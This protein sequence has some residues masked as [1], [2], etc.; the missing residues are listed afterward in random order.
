[1]STPFALLLYASLAVGAAPSTYQPTPE[2]LQKIQDKTAELGAVL[3]KIRARRVDEGLLADVEVFH[4][5]AVW[6]ARYPR[7]EFHSQK[8]VADTLLVLDRGLAR[9]KELASGRPAWPKQKG[10]LVRA[11]R[12]RVDGSVQPYGLFIPPNYDGRKPVRLDVVL[13]G[14]G[15]TLNEVSFIAARSGDVA[16]TGQT[17]SDYIRLDIYGRGNNAYRW[18]GETD[19]FE[20]LASVEKRYKIDPKR[21]V[22]RGFSMGGAGTWHLGLQYPDRW[23]AMEPGAGFTDS[24]RYMKRDDFPPHQEAMLHIYDAVDYALNAFNLPLVAYAGEEDGAAAQTANVRAQLEKEGFHFTAD[25]LDWKTKDINAIF[26]VGPKTGHKF[27]PDSKQQ[28]EAFIK[29]ALVKGR[30]PPEHIRFVTYTV[31]YNRCF[32]VQVALLEQEYQRAEVDAQRNSDGSLQITTKNVARL[33]LSEVRPVPKLLLNEAEVAIEGTRSGTSE[34]LLE[35]RPQGWTAQYVPRGSW[36]TPLP[37]RK[38]H[39]RQGPIDD[40]F[41]DSFLCVRGTGKPNHPAAQQYAQA[42]LETFNQEYSRWL[43]GDM[44]IKDDTAVTA[45]DIANHNLVLF[46]DP[47]SNKLLAQIADKLPI[48]WTKQSITLG[49]KAYSAAEHVLAMIY[50]NPLNPKRYVVLNSGHTFGVEDFRGTN[51]RLYPRLGDYAVLR[52]DASGKTTEESLQ[53]TGFFGSHWEWVSAP[54]KSE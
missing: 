35:K 23:A 51:A 17:P 52:V 24:K 12:S 49:G 44:Q 39:G 21:I 50:P 54:A 4:K 7:E 1:M 20:A 18:A 41:T 42:T 27:H 46:G 8:Y 10:T 43:R 32:W 19:V 40:A 9:A 38:T 13:H 28:S 2:E 48:R 3:Q 25:G 5:A 22:L 11:Y 34:I 36:D 53:Q 47:A 31:R 33:V 16:P 15:G 45:S 6:I 37:L 26:L 29:A 14:R 30:T